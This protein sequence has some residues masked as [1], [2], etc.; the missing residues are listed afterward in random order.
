MTRVDLYAG[1]LGVGKTT[2]IRQL[3]S[4]GYEAHRVVIIENEIGKVNFD[5]A[6]LGGAG[7]E[8]REITGGCVCCTVRGQLGEAIREIVSTLNPD[9]IVMEPSGAADVRG[10]REELRSIPEIAPGRFVLIVNAK[11]TNTLLKIIGEF[12]YDQIRCAETVYL[13]RAD[14][15][16]P[17]EV[18]SLKQSLLAVN[19]LLRFVEAPVRELSLSDFPLLEAQKGAARPPVLSRPSSSLEVRDLDAPKKIVPGRIKSSGQGGITLSTWKWK[20]PDALS[21]E[22]IRKIR[23]ILTDETQLELFRAKGFLRM[24]DGKIQKIDYVFGDY[25]A[26]E[27]ENPVCTEANE[28]VLIGPRINRTFLEQAAAKL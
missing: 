16:A 20:L 7:I 17:E 19:P 25:S 3:L 9:F 10:L 6:Y 4:N 21:E 1:L 24:K 18:I 14:Q 11:K 13:S 27:L 23:E 22:Q 28:L 5:A 15:M 8:I 2:V 12:F 26:E